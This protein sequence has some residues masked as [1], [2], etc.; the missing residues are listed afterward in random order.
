MKFYAYHFMPH[1]NFNMILK[2]RQ[3][4]H[5]LATDTCAKMDEERLTYHRTHQNEYRVGNFSELQDA[6]ITDVNINA[7]NLGIIRILPS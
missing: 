3:L 6:I 7:N 1:N 5:Q 2:S 4:F